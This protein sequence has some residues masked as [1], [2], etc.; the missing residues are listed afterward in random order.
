MADF[1]SQATAALILAKRNGIEITM[2]E[3]GQRLNMHVVG[4]PVSKDNLD[5]VKSMI[6]AS[7]QSLLQFFNN[8]NQVETIASNLEKQLDEKNEE[9][10]R[11]SDDIYRLAVQLTDIELAYG[12]VWKP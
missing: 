1:L 4:E 9:A 8:K 5:I 10:T 7:K 3:D 11:L 2:H 6:V 12:L